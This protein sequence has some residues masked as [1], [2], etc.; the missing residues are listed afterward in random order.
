MNLTKI[1]CQ[2]ISINAKESSGEIKVKNINGDTITID[3]LDIYAV[4]QGITF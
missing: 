3:I 2:L 4:T 1:K